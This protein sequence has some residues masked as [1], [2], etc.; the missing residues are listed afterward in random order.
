MADSWH[1]GV[2]SYLHHCCCRWRCFTY[3]DSKHNFTQNWT[4]DAHNMWATQAQV[5][6]DIQEE[7]QELKQPSNGLEIN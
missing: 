4:E 5:D 1:F 2:N 3:P 7:I 6:E